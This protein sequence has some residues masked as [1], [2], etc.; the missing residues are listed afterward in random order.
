VDSWRSIETVADAL[1]S[2]VDIIFSG[3]LTNTPGTYTPSRGRVRAGFQWDT[4]L[5]RLQ[6][7]NNYRQVLI[8]YQQAKRGYYRYE[9]TIWQSLRA[10]LRNIRYN[11][12]NFE[13]Q[14]YAVRI[15]AQQI[16]INEDLRQIRE[17]LNQASGPTA[18]RDSV[19]ALQDLL[20]AQNTFLGVWVFY[21]A[22]RRNLD[23]D[24]GTIRVNADNIWIDP[25]QITSAAYGFAPQDGNGVCLPCV[26]NGGAMQQSGY[27]DVPM[28][29]FQPVYGSQSGYGQQ[30]NYGAQYG[31]NQPL[32]NTNQPLGNAPVINEV[33]PTINIPSQ[34]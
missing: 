32:G 20:S 33:S 3:G 30:P 28:G 27:G 31:T 5:T 25:G 9:D 26:E 18:A 21:E 19:S 15:A 13:L 34:Y 1:E 8:E 11:Q 2:A 7:R 24:L 16:T 23:Q 22:Q 12:Y 29:D 10:N 6:Q 14:R 17:S 4:A